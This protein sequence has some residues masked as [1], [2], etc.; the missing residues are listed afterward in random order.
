MDEDCVL[1]SE[2][3]FHLRAINGLA[4]SGSKPRFRN[5]LR[6]IIS[7]GTGTGSGGGKET[8]INNHI[9]PPSYLEYIYQC[10][11]YSNSSAQVGISAVGIRFMYKVSAKDGN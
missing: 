10:Y 11:T 9:S 2:V 5:Q 4:S 8:V 3:R 7:S 1:K 6:H